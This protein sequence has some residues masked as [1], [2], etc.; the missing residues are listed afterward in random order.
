MSR[1]GFAWC[2]AGGGAGGAAGGGPFGSTAGNMGGC[3]AGGGVG[4]PGGPGAGGAG[5]AILKDLSPWPLEFFTRVTKELKA[6]LEW[7]QTCIEVRDV[8]FLLAGGLEERE[9]TYGPFLCVL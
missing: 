3:V 2:L 9:L 4:G 5:A 8:L 1:V 6:R 7:Y